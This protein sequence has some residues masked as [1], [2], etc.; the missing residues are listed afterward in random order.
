MASWFNLALFKNNF[1]RNLLLAKTTLLIFLGLFM[2]CIIAKQLVTLIFLFFGLSAVILTV[3]YPCFIQDNLINK[4]KVTVVKSLPLTTR[5]IWF[6]NYISGYLIVL[7]TLL[8]E[9]IGLAL[10]SYLTRHEYTLILNLDRYNVDNFFMMIFVLLFIYYTL[11]FFFTSMAGNRWGQI[12]FSVSG[13]AF[14]IIILF[15]I[16][17]F[18]DF[19]L[20]FNISSTFNYQL[21]NWLFP[22]LSG[23]E[24]IIS[25][26]SGEII[27]VHFI[28][29][30]VVF[31]L[32]YFVYKYRNNENVGEPLVFKQIIFIFKIILVISVTTLL[33]SL[34]LVFGKLEISLG[35][36]GIGMIFLVYVVLGLLVAGCVEIFFKTYKHFYLII[37][38]GVLVG[39]FGMT[40]LYTNNEY[41][42]R[43]QECLNTPGI[44]GVLSSNQNVMGIERDLL[45]DYVNWL[46][47]HREYIH[48]NVGDYANGFTLE[49]V[50]KNHNFNYTINLIEDGFMDYFKDNRQGVFKNY[51]LGFKDKDL[52][53][54][55]L[56]DKSYYLDKNLINELYNLVKDDYYEPD[57]FFEEDCLSLIDFRDYQNYILPNNEKITNF[58]NERCSYLTNFVSNC[59]QFIN[60]K[61]S[62]DLSD[63]IELNQY[64]KEN[65]DITNVQEIYIS[66]Y[67]LETIDDEKVTYSLDVTATNEQTS[68]HEQHLI[69]EL[70]NI[71][72]KIVIVAIKG[73]E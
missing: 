17:L 65:S 50:D 35:I 34:L 5:C 13:C 28:I 8:I 15:N 41:N 25:Q 26:T 72:E 70:R 56:G 63:F 47:T 40:Y 60:E 20:P 29:A 42:Y 54:V 46:D 52:L 66:Q 14:S 49:L 44:V 51:I 36:Q 38:V 58:L 64:I 21:Y 31:V 55:N 23:I 10:L 45:K 2:L 9:G 48:H 39:W 37:Y 30:M 32:S 62:Q 18:M 19:L 4:T 22:V 27:L 24:Y 11:I 6:T 69:I 73:G 61:L 43:K 71:D 33:F 3:L 59:D 16:V 68:F 12:V 7:I 57:L 1:K 67:K 53:M